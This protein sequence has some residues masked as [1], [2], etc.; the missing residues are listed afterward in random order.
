[1]AFRVGQKVVCISDDWEFR[2]RAYANTLP[3]AKAVY[4]V[5]EILDLPTGCGLTLEEIR[6]LVRWPDKP[7]SEAA[8]TSRAFRPLIDKS[9]DTGMAILR[10][11]LDPA[12]HKITETV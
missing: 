7:A 12:H 6:D 10:K 1:M 8:W 9:T 11:L 3:Q 5:R 2:A 4:T